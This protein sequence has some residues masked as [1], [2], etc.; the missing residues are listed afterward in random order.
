[1]ESH[2]NVRCRPSADIGGLR[3][4]FELPPLHPAPFDS[5]I[6]SSIG[7]RSNLKPDHMG[8]KEGGTET[9]RCPLGHGSAVILGETP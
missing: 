1:M 6:L 4:G 9:T 5:N 7:F 3:L 8:V 2:L